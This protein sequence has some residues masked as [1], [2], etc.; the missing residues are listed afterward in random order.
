MLDNTGIIYT[1]K[2]Q[3]WDDMLGG[4]Y[5][6]DGN[7]YTNSRICRD[8]KTEL[9]YIEHKKNIAEAHGSISEYIR[10]KITPLLTE[11]GYVILDNDFPYYL[12]KEIKH[13]ILWT[14]ETMKDERIHEIIKKERGYNEFL[15]Y[16][17]IQANKSVPDV[18]H[19][20]IMSRKNNAVE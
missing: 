8:L 19:Y 10:K 11:E 7:T 5:Y 14:A 18:H 9:E 1:D 17:N 20:H 16:A 15:A 13:E 4:L 3:S 6:E 12:E 2:I